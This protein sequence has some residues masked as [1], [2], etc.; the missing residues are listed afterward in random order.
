[1][2][3]TVEE[4]SEMIIPEIEYEKRIKI[5]TEGALC[6]NEYLKTHGG[7]LYPKLAETLG[8]LKNN[9]H[10][11]IVS[12]CLNGY[13]EAFLNYHNLNQYFDD[14]GC[15]STGLT[16][17]ENIKL[18]INRNNIEKAVYVG[19]TKSDYIAATKAGIPFIHAAYGFGSI[20]ANV[21][22]VNAF[23]DLKERVREII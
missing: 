5:V 15:Q 8:E 23:C 4:I 14:F 9:Y 7:V 11:S 10:L 17:A 13:I 21:T 19:D 16:K 3:K 18:V 6:G 22:K 2:G 12:N 20:D 1:M